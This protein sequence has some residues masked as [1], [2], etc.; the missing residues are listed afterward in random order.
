[1]KSIF[2]ITLVLF[3]L[4][5]I[6]VTGQNRVEKILQELHNSNS[7]NVLVAAHR[8]DW[9]H[10]PEN[11]IQAIE[12]CIQ[13]GVDIVEIDVQKTRDGQFILMHD[14][15]IDRTTNGKGK[16]ADYTL[17]QLKQ[18]YLKN[19]Q[20]RKIAELTDQRIPTLEEALLT[21]KGNILINLD[22]AYGYIEDIY[23]I[24]IKTGTKK[25]AL[26]KRSISKNPKNAETIKKNLFSV[27]SL[28]LFMPIIKNSLETS[29]LIKEHLQAY[30]PVAMELILSKSDSLL[31][32][33]GYIRKNGTSVW[34]NTLW[35][36]LCAGYTDARALKDPDANWGHLIQKGVN[37]FQTDNPTEL[38]QYLKEKGLRNF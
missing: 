31:N 23:P 19:R 4:F 32:E 38:I 20:G 34:V 3:M 22:K 13:M 14:R 21:V 1:M 27:D 18:F 17:Q 29:F 33:S 10:A 6:T 30:H 7:S 2:R 9:R 37:I 16:V 24:L 11:S 35:G 8:G 15:T 25:N 28:L 12:N 5:G 26:F 36:S